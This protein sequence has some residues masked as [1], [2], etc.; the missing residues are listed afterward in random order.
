[1]TAV[2]LGIVALVITLVA[3]N[4][5]ALRGLFRALRALTGNV[6]TNRRDLVDP[7]TMERP[8]ADR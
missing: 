7:L 8:H 1:M 4:V 3:A 5:I 6:R 2:G